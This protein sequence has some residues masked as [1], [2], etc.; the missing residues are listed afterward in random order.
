MYG[1][2][3]HVYWS[4]TLELLVSNCVKIMYG[5]TFHNYW[6]DTFI[7]VR[8]L[9]YDEEARVTNGTVIN[10]ILKGFQSNWMQECGLDSSGSRWRT[11]S[12]HVVILQSYQWFHY[13]TLHL[14]VNDYDLHLSILQSNTLHTNWQVSFSIFITVNHCAWISQCGID[15]IMIL[16]IIVINALIRSNSEK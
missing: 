1:T 3:T 6:N 13:I 11:A 5:I 2:A 16:I 8:N 7:N 9:T 15:T 14:K 4:N 12:F 10:L